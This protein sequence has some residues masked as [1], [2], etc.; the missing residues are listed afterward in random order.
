MPLTPVVD[1]MRLGL[2][3]VDRDGDHLGTARHVR[4]GGALARR[5]RGVGA[6]RPL[7]HPPVVPLGA[8]PPVTRAN[9]GVT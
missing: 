5:R 1:L 7:G 6:D 8:A 9:G 4:R 3:G 2:L